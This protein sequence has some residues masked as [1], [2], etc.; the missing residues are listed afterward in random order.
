MA[1]GERRA[2]E[3]RFRLK[4]ID[5]LSAVDPTYPKELARGIV[6]YRL[7]RYPLAVEAFRQHLERSPDGA[8]SLRAQNYLR[9]ALGKANDES[10]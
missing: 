5:E 1:E 9:A 10:F 2:F 7:G 6:L 3:D 8:F 4:K